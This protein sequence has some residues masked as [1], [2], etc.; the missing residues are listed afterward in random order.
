M[1]VNDS[2]TDGLFD[3]IRGECDPL[4]GD[5]LSVASAFDRILPSGDIYALMDEYDNPTHFFYRFDSN[6]TDSVND[7]DISCDCGKFIDGDGIQSLDEIKSGFI[8]DSVHKYDLTE[9]DPRY[10]YPHMVDEDLINDICYYNLN[11]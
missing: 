5:C 1:S 2:L 9:E 10:D 8:S 11:N 3:Y 4:T 6:I 7:N